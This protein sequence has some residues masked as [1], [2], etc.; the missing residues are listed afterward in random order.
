M[1]IRN[2]I[3]VLRDKS[4]CYTDVSKMMRPSEHC[5]RKAC[6]AII[7]TP[8]VCHESFTEDEGCGPSTLPTYGRDTGRCQ[9]PPGGTV[10][11]RYGGERQGV[12]RAEKVNESELLIKR[13]NCIDDVKTRVWTGPWE[14]HGGYWPISRKMTGESHPI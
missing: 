3:P 12:V 13:R 14:K 1:Q 2:P 8:S 5:L 10:P 6:D 4:R 11:K 7:A 9:I